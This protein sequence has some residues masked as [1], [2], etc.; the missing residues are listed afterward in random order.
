MSRTEELLTALLNGDTA[1]IEPRSRAEKYL[2]N[3]V[4]ACGCDGL[5]T[6][7]SR[8]DA[9]LYALADKMAS[10]GSGG[11]GG[12]SDSKFK[13]LLNKTITELTEDDFNASSSVATYA[14]V[15]CAELVKVTIPE[16]VVSIGARAFY[17]CGKLVDLTL[18]ESLTS[19]GDYAFYQNTA[20]KRLSIPKNVKTIGSYAFQNC[21]GVEEIYYDASSAND[22][23]PKA[24]CFTN[25]GTDTSGTKLT[26]GKNVNRIPAYMFCAS[27]SST[28]ASNIK[29]VIFESA[30]IE[31]GTSAFDY[32]PVTDVYYPSLEGWCN[33][34]FANAAA[35]PL[36][37]GANLYVNNALV[38]AL[39]I[40]NSI[41]ALYAYTFYK[42]SSVTSVYVPSSVVSSGSL[43]FGSCA[44]LVSATVENGAALGSSMFSNCSKLTTVNVGSG[45]VSKA[46]TS[47]VNGCKNI[48]NLTILDIKAS[49]QVGSGTS[50]GHNLTL[51]SL[52][53]LVAECV[54]T[55]SACT[56][57][58]GSSNLT[59]L[60]AVYV[61]V[62][63]DTSSKLPFEQCEST[64]ER[65][66]TIQDYLALK[67][68]TIA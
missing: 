11:G 32:V 46:S 48:T 50:Y 60:A 39:N 1:N 54:N 42:C 56:L 38:T 14:C 53:G 12:G 57:T 68:W 17:Q 45:Y 62:T 40:P 35:S 41:T 18:P 44:N 33:T 49:I 9:L 30:V 43:V 36:N 37:K 55:G 52:L 31:I 67:N 22:V 61:K 16:S 51:D 4:K 58:V 27:S 34:Y 25:V 47:P 20:L 2:L 3:C 7:Q 24:Y 23:I 64:D 66:L 29:T 5:P 59:K 15:S 19:I 13:S 6:P 28:I 21:K 26:I 63:D 8:L 10:G 65:A